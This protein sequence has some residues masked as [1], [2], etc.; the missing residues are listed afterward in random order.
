MRQ[1]TIHHP[2]STNPPID[3]SSKSTIMYKN[4]IL[5]FQL[6]YYFPLVVLGKLQNLQILNGRKR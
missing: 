6:A 5:I 4:L 3:F 2:P 1:S